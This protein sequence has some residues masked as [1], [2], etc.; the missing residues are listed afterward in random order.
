MF[1]Q[2]DGIAS[3]SFECP[4]PFLMSELQ[5]SISFIWHF[6]SLCNKPRDQKLDS[7][8]FLDILKSLYKNVII[9]VKL[10]KTICNPIL[11][12]YQNSLSIKNPVTYFA[13]VNV[14]WLT[15]WL[16]SH[17]SIR[18]MKNVKKYEEAGSRHKTEV[19]EYNVTSS[20]IKRF[21]LLKTSVN[22]WRR[23]SRES[24]KFKKAWLVYRSSVCEIYLHQYVCLENMKKS[25]TNCFC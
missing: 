7:I 23:L 18:Q 5:I 25:T 22:S 17:E 8:L 19:H 20:T 4:L 10:G 2:N 13:Q 1:P 15:D 16:T 21:V 6:V 11:C 12:V 3:Y 9:E 24:P 14:T